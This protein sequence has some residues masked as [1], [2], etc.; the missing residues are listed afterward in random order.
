MY[1][2]CTPPVRMSRSGRET[3][4][5]KSFVFP[6]VLKREAWADIPII[7]KDEILLER[8]QQEVLSRVTSE[9]KPI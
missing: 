2:F 4:K 3:G 8:K 7:V 5:A 6:F 1:S 9:E